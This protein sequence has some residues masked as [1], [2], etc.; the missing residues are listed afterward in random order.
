MNRVLV[1]GSINMDVV[2]TASLYPKMGETVPGQ[3]VS[4]FPGGKGANQAVS[5][6]R[7][8][9]PTALIGRIGQDA[10]GK[11]LRV[12][13]A[14]QGID[15]SHVKESSKPHTGTAVILI[16]GANNA[17]VA[18]PG[19]NALVSKGDVSEPP[20]EA[21]DVLV[22]QFEIPVST[23]KAFFSRGRS[24]GARTVLNPAPAIEFDHELL[25]LVDVLVL[26]ESELAF[27]TKRILN[28]DDDISRF[29]EAAR[30]LRVNN[31]Q[32]ICVTLG[33]RGVVAL[34]EDE[35]ITIPGR[36]VKA[37]DATGAGDCFVGA[38]AAQLAAG[39]EIREALEYANVAASVCV[40]RMGA[41]PSMPTKSEVLASR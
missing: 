37:I 31:Q 2:A 39:E 23:I 30:S 14:N 36:K 11:E 26:N 21:G 12:F 16:V 22:S 7:L 24:S 6:A 19:A 34:V 38:V 9:A 13:L 25:G 33:A 5:A 1:A 18:V 29:I 40:Q 28:E 27:L 41:G 32:V 15:V 4:F 10:F 8:G 35:V 17:I 20:I 3:E